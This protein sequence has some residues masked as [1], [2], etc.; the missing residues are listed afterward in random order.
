[1][2]MLLVLTPA[3]IVISAVQRTHQKNAQLEG[4]GARLREI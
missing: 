2:C 4:H 3:M 1:M